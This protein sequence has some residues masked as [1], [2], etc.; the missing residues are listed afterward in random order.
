MN[1][2]RDPIEDGVEPCRRPWVLQHAAGE[3]EG[4]GVEQSPEGLV[5][6]IVARDVPLGRDIRDLGHG[7]HVL[8]VEL[9][10]RRVGLRVRERR[11][12]VGQELA[13]LAFP[14]LL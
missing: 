2:L 4:G 10:D 8:P 1:R 11:I 6:P 3:N 9:H 13:V 7:N 12:L 14:L 5:A